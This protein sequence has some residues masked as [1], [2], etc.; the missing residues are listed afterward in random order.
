MIVDMNGIPILKNNLINNDWISPDV[1][2]SLVLLSLLE[3]VVGNISEYTLVNN[4]Y[5]K[6]PDLTLKQVAEIYT[7]TKKKNNSGLL[8]I[9]FER[10]V[11]DCIISSY[12]NVIDPLLEIL[13]ELDNIFLKGDEWNV[14]PGQR[15]ISD[16][17]DVILWGDEKG[18]WLRDFQLINPII[19][20]NDFVI[21]DNILYNFKNILKEIST[22]N[23]LYSNLGKAD[24]FIKQKNYN[25]WHSV[26]IKINVEDLNR[27]KDR[28]D[29]GIALRNNN[30]SDMTEIIKNS[31]YINKKYDNILIFNKNFSFNAIL[32]YYFECLDKFLIEINR[33][34]YSGSKKSLILSSLPQ[35]FIWLYN[36][37]NETIFDIINH[38]SNSLTNQTGIIIPKPILI[39]NNKGI[40]LVNGELYTTSGETI[41]NPIELG[42]SVV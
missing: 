10:F 27:K 30:I 26:D 13:Y 7:N 31:N 6:K 41:N 23:S 14:Q 17:I 22:R 34:E 3:G 15:K 12:K 24:L 8:G 18:K 25:I 16:K 42:L 37:R 21:R 33:I 39:N 2:I 19:S 32:T 5:V 38:L 28:L 9:C 35:E 1:K 36:C 40:L 4:N 29:I 20:D 11:Y